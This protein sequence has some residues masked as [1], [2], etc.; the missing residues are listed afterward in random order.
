MKL[1]I[2]ACIGVKHVLMCVHNAHY[3]SE[4]GE[5]VSEHIESPSDSKVLLYDVILNYIY[6]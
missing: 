6:H 5:T 1:F 2:C 3:Y 4:G